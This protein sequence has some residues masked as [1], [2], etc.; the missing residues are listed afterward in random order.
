MIS[1]CLSCSAKLRSEPS[2]RPPSTRFV[3]QLSRVLRARRP[4]DPSLYQQ[5]GSC[6]HLQKMVSWSALTY[7]P[8]RHPS[9]IPPAALYCIPEAMK[10]MTR[11]EHLSINYPM[12]T[13]EQ[14]LIPSHTFPRLRKYAF[15]DYG[16]YDGPLMI[17]FLTRHPTLTHIR[18]GYNSIERPAM[19][20]SVRISLPNLEYYV[21]PAELIP[22]IVACGLREARLRWRS[23]ILYRT[24]LEIDRVISGLNSLTTSYIPF[25]FSN[26]SFWRGVTAPLLTSIAKHMP[27]IKTL[28]IES[29][30]NSGELDE[31]SFPV[32]DR[33][34][35]ELNRQQLTALQPV[36]RCSRASCILQWD[37][38]VNCNW[39]ISQL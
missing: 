28:R 20:P 11:L 5:S 17:S 9:P 36:F 6:E 23:E 33:P 14:D 22:S 4:C 32:L 16:G 27:H 8:D 10:L 1:L 2:A 24:E 30:L 39:R 26:N 12:L 19:T 31:V 29:L 18:L 38:I 25:V 7:I 21:G 13:Q 34:S 3:R 15:S 35:A 37:T